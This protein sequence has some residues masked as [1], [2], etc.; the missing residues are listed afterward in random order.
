MA[1][2]DPNPSPAARRR[3]NAAREEADKATEDA[4]RLFELCPDF[5]RV[6]ARMLE[7]L[8]EAARNSPPEARAFG[9]KAGIQYVL[10]RFDIR[11]ESFLELVS[12]IK[13]QN[14]FMVVLNHFKRIAWEEYSGGPIEIIRPA[15]AQAYADLEA[16][17]AK[18][19]PRICEGYERLEFLRNGS[20]AGKA[21]TPESTEYPAESS[22]GRGAPTDE[23]VAAADKLVA[24]KSDADIQHAAWYL[25]CTRQH[26]LR[27]IRKGVLT[28]TNTKPKRVRCDSLRRHKWGS[29]SVPKESP[30][31]N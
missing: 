25:R 30:D 6:V 27:L 8:E 19:Q 28:A 18:V 26:V 13:L 3:L 10:S 22:R 17:Q 9:S 5:P 29:D 1:E 20:L 4:V 11:A 14:A 21:Q 16:I 12:D 7:R 2:F 23:Q 31:E 15:S 24:G